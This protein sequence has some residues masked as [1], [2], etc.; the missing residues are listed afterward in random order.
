MHRSAGQFPDIAATQ[1]ELQIAPTVGNNLSRPALFRLNHC[2][3]MASKDTGALKKKAFFRRPFSPTCWVLDFS[4]KG[5]V[6]IPF[7]KVP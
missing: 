3:T 1:S 2:L 5:S 7:S 6:L 4:H